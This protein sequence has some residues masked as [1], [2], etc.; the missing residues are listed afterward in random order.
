VPRD[1]RLV[2]LQRDRVG[3]HRAGITVAERVRGIVQRQ[4]PRRAARDR[5]VPLPAGSQS[6]G[7][8][9]P[10]ALQHLPAPFLARLPDTERVHARLEQQQPRTCKDT[11]ALDEGRSKQLWVVPIFGLTSA[12]YRVGATIASCSHSEPNSRNRAIHALHRL[13]VVKVRDTVEPLDTSLTPTW[14]WAS[15]GWHPT[16][17]LMRFFG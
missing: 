3:V 6:H 14:Q 10:P 7:R 2:P 8:G 9:L 11:G 5:D 15:E 13:P 17:G 4:T 12:Y 1:R 16:L